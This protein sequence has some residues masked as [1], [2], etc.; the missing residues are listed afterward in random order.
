MDATRPTKVR[1]QRGNGRP[2]PEDTTRPTKGRGGRDQSSRI[3]ADSDRVGEGLGWGA[4][5]SAGRASRSRARQ[6]APSARRS[7]L[8]KL[9]LAA[10]LIL[11]PPALALAIPI[12][13]DL[14]GVIL[15]GVQIGGVPLQGMTMEQA[16][17]E[18]DRVWNRELQLTAVDISDPSRAWLASPSEFGL[19]VDPQQNAAR[20]YAIGRGQG[21]VQ[22]FLS[23]WTGWGQPLEV[24]P[25]VGFD[26]LVALAAYDR[27]APRLA[28]PAS[29]AGLSLGADSVLVAESRLGRELD[30]LASLEWLAADP[31]SAMVDHGL[32][33]L[34]TRSVEP[35]VP[36]VRAQVAEIERLLT[37]EP[38]ITAYDPV[39]DEWLRWQ[40]DPGRIASWI[41]ISRRADEIS[42]GLHEDRMLEYVQML[43]QEVGPDREFDAEAALSALYAD[44]GGGQADPMILRY[45]PRE[46]V[47][48]GGETINS[49][50]FAHGI[51]AWKWIELNPQLK[52]RGVA[53]GETLV[54]PPRDAMLELPVV[55]EKRIVVSLSEQRMW[56]YQNGEL[57]DEQVVSTGIARSPTMPGI[58]QIKSHYL[59][60]YASNW[61]LYMPHFMGIYDAVPGFE[62]GFHGLPL[63]SNGVRLWGNVL[64]RPASYGCIILTLEA[65]EK[66]YDWAEEG[67]VVEIQR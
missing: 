26:P 3:R 6:V 62:N 35:G 41:E 16:A 59:N 12:Y 34:V 28:V 24:L 64:G 9:A 11:M 14:W 20:A 19:W 63:L 5:M 66:L 52:T 61:D 27:W 38:V 31:R 29:D 8:P 42:I 10:V 36:D 13:F 1:R 54:M 48:R 43:V 39:T 49:I 47:V 67:V 18:L 2:P 57:F 65:A 44:L 33:P 15:P 58:F 21:L 23:I 60:A 37:S 51:P 55:Q 45:R 17:A 40:P 46:Y 56:A 22:G 7:R 32:I 25:Q 30:L 53:V 4:G 50:G